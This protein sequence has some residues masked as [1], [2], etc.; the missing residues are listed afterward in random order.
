MN[1]NSQSELGVHA[2]GLRGTQL[3]GSGEILEKM[4]LTWV[5]TDL[6]H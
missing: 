2:Q 6:T 5:Q 4:G 3:R 1:D